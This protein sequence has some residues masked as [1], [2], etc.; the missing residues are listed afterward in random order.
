[1]KGDIRLV[2]IYIYVYKYSF[3]AFTGGTEVFKTSPFLLIYSHPYMTCSK[4]LN[5]NCILGWKENWSSTRLNISNSWAW[6]QNHWSLAFKCH[7]SLFILDF[8][9]SISSFTFHLTDLKTIGLFQYPLRS[10]L[11]K[12]PNF[13]FC[14]YPLIDSDQ[15]NTWILQLNGMAGLYML[16]SRA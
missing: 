3:W 11:R 6:C 13:Q 12:M 14:H 2:Y 10:S 15:S 9:W 4:L 1:M 5:F 16:S 8:Y 7:T